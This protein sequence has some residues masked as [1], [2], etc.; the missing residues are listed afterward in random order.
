MM[1]R[2][3]L[4]ALAAIALVPF[5][6]QA[7][8]VPR[9][10]FDLKLKDYEVKSTVFN[11]PSGLRVVFQ[12]D[13]TQ[14]IVSATMV[15]DKGSTADPVGRE[16]IAHLVE[17]LWFRSKHKDAQGNE[18]PKVWDL[19][20]E[21]GAN[22]NAS[23]AGDW[24]N[25]MTVVPKEQLRAVMRL[26][27]L[28]L[29]EAVAGV[30]DEVIKVEREVVRNEL[31]MRYENGGG[32]A[33]R[34]LA[35]KLYPVGHPYA[36]LGIGTHDSLNAITLGDVQQFVKTNYV[37]ANATL[38]VVG[39][40]SIADAPRLL[41]EDMGIDVLRDPKNPDAPLQ[42]LPD[43][44]PRVNGPSEEPPPPAQPF[45]TK[46]EVT[47]LTTEH[48][49]V[50]K[51]TLLLGWTLPGGYRANQVDMEMAGRLLTFAVAQELR[52]GWEW[53]DDSTQDESFGCFLGTEKLASYA[54]CFVEIGED[55][56]PA[57][58]AERAA[59]GLQYLWS[60]DEIY[61]QIQEVSF[62]S[63][64]Q[65]TMAGILQS[66]DLISSIGSGRATEL[67]A[68]THYTGDIKY[69]SSQFNALARVN[70]ENVRAIAQKYLNRNRMV[71]V[72][73]KPQEEGDLTID[74]SNAQYRGERR[75]DRLDTVLTEAQLTNDF[76]RKAVTAPDTKKANEFTLPN[77]VR[78][79]VMQHSQA[80]IV[81]TA[82]SFEGGS[83]GAM[84]NEFALSNFGDQ[85]TANPLRVAG[86]AWTDFEPLRTRWYAQ[87]SAGNL[88]ELLF[89]IR[90]SLDTIVPNTDGRIDQSKSLKKDILRGL[91]EPADVASALRYN[92]VLPNHPYS[93]QM[94]HADVD[95]M[96]KYNVGVV[97]DVLSRILRPDRARLYI[98]GN[99][100]L[101][102]AKEAATV[103][104]GGWTGYQKPPTAGTPVKV[105]YD[106]PT[107][108]ASR[109][110]VVVDKA[111]SSQSD[112]T[113]LCQLA[114]IDQNTVAVGQV[115][116][117]T[118]S[119][120]TWLALR[121]Q[122][123][124]SYGAYAGVS[125]QPGGLAFL[126]MSGLIQN[127]QAGLAAKTFIDLAERAMK[128]AYD[129]KTVQLVKYSRAQQ[130]VQGQQ[131]TEQM[132]T[133]LMGVL[134]IGW[135]LS[136]FDRYATMLSEV[137]QSDF[138]PLLKPCIGHEIVTVVGPKEVLTPIFEKAG[139]PWELYDIKKAKT[140]Y[141]VKYGLKLPKEEPEDEKKK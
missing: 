92:H 106:P 39:D 72:L 134:D 8:S 20:R 67:A 46:G 109:K 136:F 114:P 74:S 89:V 130:Y 101:D 22:L 44:P 87:G 83:Y 34:Y 139:L 82:L 63:A 7:D 43:P 107:A 4:L 116:G 96:S 127:D 138:A 91:K 123:G 113:F 37:P 42:N 119:E 108:P 52:P 73:M 27:G 9:P 66:V 93:H 75:E 129:N 38:V 53:D 128:G 64:K 112:V 110:V 11:F 25:Y 40:F 85:S 97:T 124:A 95:E 18:L 13:H 2:S 49:A 135:P 58:M 126:T 117:D 48:S 140:D 99:V 24:T 86:F 70:G 122:T 78:V 16:G 1:P 81:H 23:T 51:P 35:E 94:N 54:V 118:I 28:R 45:Y 5:F 137:K 103:Y 10:R 105:Q 14:P 68:Y 79:V 115:L 77:G 36:R 17:H 3:S 84:A 12:E 19:L 31:R 41:G 102:E 60:T 65:Q 33:F 125:Q 69:Y 104:F 131:S 61:R 32:D 132:L 29:R 30:T 100:T 98:V 62:S 26:E 59:N 88:K 71:A 56:D 90:D 141:Y 6:A 133:R 121:E 15:F 76:I 111:N 47:G 80:P 21:M 55:D 50:Q 57:Q 120:S